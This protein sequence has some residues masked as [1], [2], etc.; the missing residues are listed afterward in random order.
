MHVLDNFDVCMNCHCTRKVKWTLPISL[1]QLLIPPPHATSRW[2]V[3]S[4]C[5]SLWTRQRCS[6]SLKISP[7]TMAEV[8]RANRQRTWDPIPASINGV[9]GRTSKLTMTP[10]FLEIS[11]QCTRRPVNWNKPR[12]TNPVPGKLY[13]GS[14]LKN[15]QTWNQ[16][17][18]WNF[19]LC[20]RTS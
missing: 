10:I 20:E 14:M 5:T 8:S 2:T 7:T 11:S 13:P 9:C 18:S 12:G 17:P 15:Q 4:I 19:L 6:C 16:T 3:W 1:V